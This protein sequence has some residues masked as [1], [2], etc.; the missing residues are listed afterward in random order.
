MS[1]TSLDGID[2]SILKTNGI[3]IFE[4]GPNYFTKFSKELYEKLLFTLTLKDEL[5][6]HKDFFEDLNLLF[7]RE[8][9]YSILNF[10]DK[11]CIELI[12]F[13]G[14]T[15]YHDPK[16]QVSIQLGDG[17]LIS[18]ILNKKL[19]YNFRQNDL[20]HNGQGA[21]LAPIYHKLIIEDLSLK[22]PSCIL[23]IGGISNITY[24]D[25]N[26]LI[27]F[28]TG[29]GNAIINDLM[30]KL[31]NK[32]FDESGEVAYTGKILNKL[33]DRLL[34]DDFF[35]LKYPKSLDRQYFNHYLKNFTEKYKPNDLISTFSEFTALSI[36]NSLKLLPHYPKN[37]II[38]GGGSK[39]L[40]I[41][42]RLK[43]HLKCKIVEE[44]KSIYHPDFIESQLMGLLAVRSINN[45][46][47]T[48]PLTT[49]VS[50]PLSGGELCIPKENH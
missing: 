34:E 17:K 26:D 36:S 35:K 7:S 32:N 27:G 41:I 4:F 23:N 40:Y 28:D 12:G 19:I 33:I 30:L 38:M 11:T 49:G 9:A 29:P 24:W 6:L 50:K 46:P 43:K 15:I 21:P 37:I 44:K 25:G 1:G 45:L 13:H 42:K 39:N 16:N 5:S 2:M 8:Y 20:F 18:N 48:F 10:I 3:N 22:L 47:Y 14:Q 31:F